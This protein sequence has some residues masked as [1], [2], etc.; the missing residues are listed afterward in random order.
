MLRV[1]SLVLALLIGTAAGAGEDREFKECADCPV[2]VGIPGGRFQMGSPLSEAGRFDSEGP[3]HSVTIRPFALTKTLVTV[4]DYLKFLR[5]TGYQP[6]PCDPVL[7][8]QWHSPGHGRA[9]PP[10]D[11]EPRLWPATCLNW[12]DAQAY[13][14]W[15]N[16][17]LQSAGSQ[18]RYRLP[19]E[20][21]WE[22]A[23]R[24]GKVSARWWGETIGKGNANCAGC[25][26]PW[27]GREI[28]PVASF[29]VNPF[30][31]EDMLGNVWQW[32][33]DCWNDSYVG[34]PSDGSAWLSG[35]CQRRVIRGGSWSSLP[36]FIR[37]AARSAFA[38]D[39]KAFDYSSYAGFRLARSLP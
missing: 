28:A 35:D 19:S 6:D 29:G 18:A 14:A 1:A 15:L 10:A 33:E 7:G 8:L 22:Y 16:G 27:D 26:S 5:A 36:V 30:G 4:D 34:A 2:M 32:V 17:R 13:I 23:A 12:H 39:G 31:I 9:T 21:E 24:G 38:A 3:Q 37:S 20:A 11:T 25:G